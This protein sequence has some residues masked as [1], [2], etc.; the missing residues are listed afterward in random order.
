M[1]VRDD[2]TGQV[3]WNSSPNS[4]CPSDNRTVL[5]LQ[6]DSNF[7][8]YCYQNGTFGRAIWASGTVY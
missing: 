3:S 4:T 7:V 5:A 2:R 6:S 8:M 1:I